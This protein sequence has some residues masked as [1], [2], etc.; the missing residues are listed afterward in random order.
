MCFEDTVGKTIASVKYIIR[1]GADVTYA[2][3]AYLSVLHDGSVTAETADVSSGSFVITLSDLPTDYVPAVTAAD[4]PESTYTDGTLTYD[5]TDV[6]PGSYTVEV[7]DESG[8][9]ASISTTV[10]LTTDNLP[11]TFDSDSNTIIAADDASE[12]DFANYLSNISTATVN[13]TLYSLSGYGST[14]I[15][16]TST[17]ALNLSLTTT[18]ADGNTVSFFKAE[19]TYEI[20]VSAAGYSTDL[21]FTFSIALGDIDNDGQIGI[22]DAYAVQV[23]FANLAAGNDANFT[24]AQN[25]S[26]DINSDGVLNVQ[27]AYLIQVYFAQASAGLDPTW[28]SVLNA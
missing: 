16:D 22:Q 15:L 20:T 24:D 7:T 8:V 2:T 25:I 3:E 23:E 12:T 6:L 17:G 14:K 5:A 21:T 9:Y 10:T 28:D 19:E 11:A 1:D 4:L 27:D 13:G 26:A 18:D